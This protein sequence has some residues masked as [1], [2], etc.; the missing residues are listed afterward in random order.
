MLGKR[1]QQNIKRMTHHDQTGCRAGFVSASDTKCDPLSQQ[2]RGEKS[3]ADINL[4][5]K[6][7]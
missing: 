4:G 3:Y 1:S 2:A 5:R 6:I 7:S